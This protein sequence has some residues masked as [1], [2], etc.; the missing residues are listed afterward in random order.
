MFV[1]KKEFS[2]LTQNKNTSTFA[3]SYIK[4]IL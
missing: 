4:I 2:M 3:N 1:L